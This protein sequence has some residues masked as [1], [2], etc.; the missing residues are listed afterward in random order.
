LPVQNVNVSAG[1]E[2]GIPTV[3]PGGAQDGRLSTDSVSGIAGCEKWRR[4]C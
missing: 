1:R 2:S 3:V 4:E